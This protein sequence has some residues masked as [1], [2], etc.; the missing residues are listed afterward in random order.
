MRLRDAAIDMTLLFVSFVSLYPGEKSCAVQA[1][2]QVDIYLFGLVEPG[3]HGRNVF[4]FFFAC[5]TEWLRQLLFCWL[6]M[7]V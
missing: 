5:V 2:G 3:I 4:V 1:E 7:P 6:E